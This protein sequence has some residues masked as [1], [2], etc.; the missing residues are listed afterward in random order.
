M[1][2]EDCQHKAR[3]TAERLDLPDVGKQRHEKAK[4]AGVTAVVSEEEREGVSQF[5]H[6]LQPTSQLR[7][8]LFI[9]WVCCFTTPPVC[10]NRASQASIVTGTGFAFDYERL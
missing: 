8:C 10:L 7:C 2:G 1:T 5:L 9:T 3:V 6:V 4:E